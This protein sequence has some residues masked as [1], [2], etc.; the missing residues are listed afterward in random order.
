[1]FCFSLCLR[2][3]SGGW[4]VY[5]YEKCLSAWKV[6]L[7]SGWHYD[8][9]SLF[10]PSPYFIFCAFILSHPWLLTSIQQPHPNSLSLSLSPAQS[11]LNHF[12]FSSSLLLFFS[13]TQFKSTLQWDHIRA[14]NW[15][16]IFNVL[17]G[18]NHLENGNATVKMSS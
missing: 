12:L 7:L 17:R 5:F 3:R 16:D 1:M 10:H 15:K 8:L 4:K 13:F 6:W 18:K 2:E 11:L 9:T 14:L